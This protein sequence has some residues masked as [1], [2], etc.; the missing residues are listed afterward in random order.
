[1]IGDGN[2]LRQPGLVKS[3]VTAY[4]MTNSCSTSPLRLSIFFRRRFWRA[5]RNPGP[6]GGK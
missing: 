6:S 5:E 1:V 2:I 4:L 3:Y